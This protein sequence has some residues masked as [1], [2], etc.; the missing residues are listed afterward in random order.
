MEEP[1]D[2]KWEAPTFKTLSSPG[3]DGKVFQINAGDIAQSRN[4][5]TQTGVTS[6]GMNGGTLTTM[7]LELAVNALFHR[8]T[9]LEKANAPP[10]LVPGSDA[11]MVASDAD[12]QAALAAARSQSPKLRHAFAHRKMTD[13]EKQRREWIQVGREG[14]TFD[15]PSD[16][17]IRYGVGDKWVEKIVSGKVTAGNELYGS[18]PA[19]GVPKEM[20]AEKQPTNHAAEYHMWQRQRAGRRTYRARR[21]RLTRHR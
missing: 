15:F 17:T 14:E 9:Q 7:K 4:D 12:A 8:V 6:I 19:P 11:F 20:W 3:W 18:D 1:L 21:S 10:E 16:T 13:E 2:P 5:V